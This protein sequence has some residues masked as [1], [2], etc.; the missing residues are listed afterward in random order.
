[1][2]LFP[3][4]HFRYPGLTAD[5]ARPVQNGIYYA[6]EVTFM[7]FDVA[8]VGKDKPAHYLDWSQAEQVGHCRV[9][10]GIVFFRR[11]FQ[12]MRMIVHL[13]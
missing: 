11:R 4:G 5:D 13:W 7:C 9:L 8:I 3:H 10:R 6:P 1:M 2:A 12:W